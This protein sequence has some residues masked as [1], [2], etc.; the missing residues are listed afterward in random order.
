MEA[1]RLL[2]SEVLSR[3]RI[4]Q[5]P[6]ASHRTF[7]ADSASERIAGGRIYD[8]QIAAIAR[9]AGAKAVVTGN[10]KHFAPLLRHGIQVLDPAAL[11][12]GLKAR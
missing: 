12:A 5:L 8:A 4:Q 3:F 10:G 9:A 1:F 11:A 6:D 2:D 7:I